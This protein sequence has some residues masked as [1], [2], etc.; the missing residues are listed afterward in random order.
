MKQP[1]T[2]TL[3]EYFHTFRNVDLLVD[4]F[5]TILLRNWSY[6]ERSDNRARGFTLLSELV[7]DLLDTP[8]TSQQASLLLRQ[9]LTWCDCGPEPAHMPTLTRSRC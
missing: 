5:Q 7:L 9:L 6:F 4:G 3:G 1:S 2:E 8:L